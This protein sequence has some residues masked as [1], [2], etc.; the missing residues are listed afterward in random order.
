MRRGNLFW[1]GLI[2]I[3]GLLFLLDTLNIIPENI[4]IWGIFWPALLIVLG[5]WFLAGPALFRR[6]ILDK[7]SLSIPMEGAASAK[8]R[9]KHGAGTLKVGAGTEPGVLLAGDFSGGVEQVVTHEGDQLKVKLKTPTYVWPSVPSFSFEGLEWNVKLNR[10]IPIR[11]DVNSG[12]SEID[13]DLSDLK[14]IEF[15]LETGASSSKVILPAHAGETRVRVDSGAA[16]VDIEVPEGVAASIDSMVALGSTSV[17]Q[18]R[19]PSQG[20][21][22]ISPDYDTAPNRV[23]IVVKTG[24]G[25]A[26]IH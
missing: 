10:D 9:F 26:K 3:L 16:S 17:D 14:V 13:L 6:R 11:L 18:S 5:I 4:N 19:F 25:E 8:V 24:V 23:D 7:T 22:N 20:G 15:N 21:R 1:G 12:A 2:L